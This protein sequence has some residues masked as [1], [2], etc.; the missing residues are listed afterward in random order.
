[1]AAREAIRARFWTPRD[2]HP[3]PDDL[4]ALFPPR[5]L[6]AHGRDHRPHR[7]REPDRL[8]P[9][10]PAARD[11]AHDREHEPP[12]RA[13]PAGWRSC[14][15]RTGASS[16]RPRVIGASATPGPSSRSRRRRVREFVASL[17]SD[18]PMTPARVGPDLRSLL[19]GTANLALRFGEPVGAETFGPPPRA[20]EDPGPRP[21]VPPGVRLVLSAAPPHWGADD[22][23]YAYLVSSLAMGPEGGASLP[24]DALF[25]SPPRGEWSRD[26]ATL[27]RAL[28]AVKPVLLPDAEAVIV[29][30]HPSAEALAAS[31]IGGVGAGYRVEDAVIADADEGAPGVV[32]LALGPSTGSPEREPTLGV[33]RPERRSRSPP[34][35]A[36]VADIAVAVLQL[37][38]EPTAFERLLGE[39]LVGLDH[40]GH[41]RRLVGV[42]EESATG[43]RRA[44]GERPLRRGAGRR[45]IEPCFRQREQA[46]R[47]G[48][49][50]QG[51][52]RPEARRLARCRPR[53]RPGAADSRHDPT[54]AQ[55]PQPSPPRRARR[56]RLVDGR[57]ARP[58]GSRRCRCRSA[59][60][61][62]CSACSRPA[63]TSPSARS[64]SASRGSSG[65][66]RPWMP[67]SSR[68][69]SRAIA[70][71]ASRSTGRSRPTRRCP[72]ATR[73]T[74]RSSGCSSSSAIGWACARGRPSES[75]AGATGT[76]RSADLLS[77]PEQRVYLPLVAPGTQEALD[78][79]DCLWYVRGR[80]AFLFDIEWMAA[81][82]EPLRRRGPRIETTESLVRFLVVP[83]E[84]GELIRLR[85]ARSPLLRERLRADNWHIL[86]WS[87]VRR[88]FE[89]GRS[90]LAALSPF[91]GLDP[92]VERG[93]DQMPDVRELRGRMNR[94]ARPCHPGPRVRRSRLGRV[95]RPGSA[96]GH[97]T[98]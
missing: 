42:T 80:G 88:L 93:D 55:P 15:S 22:L 59:S 38:G 61:G 19:D 94:I 68:P 92:P 91:I 2:D 31:V 29:L 76:A 75:S 6:V 25:G 48:D 89:S 41:L 87:N 7:G 64:A 77:E 39:V 47:H 16:R 71:G 28:T 66:P 85:L 1:M 70:R 67:S 96:V 62:R 32:R 11:R 90:D 34:S 57:R 46:R 65:A 51:R 50:Q 27:R 43:R 79:I 13:I 53:L 20:G 21:R 56:G 98:G 95:P 78:E 40:L 74:G 86:K 58:R 82:D 84:R 49:P 52:P 60:S 36:A 30:A 10:R 37:R 72:T 81:F 69:A 54:R 63:G 23:A 8:D 9:G 45:G 73:S 18:G 24:L 4:V 97:G 35:R 17:E 44:A 26:A 5:S 83:D 3:L 14:A 12:E 33:G